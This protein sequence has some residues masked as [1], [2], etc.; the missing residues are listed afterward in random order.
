MFFIIAGALLLAYITGVFVSMISQGDPA[1]MHIVRKLSYV[2]NFIQK[3][4]VPPYLAKKVRRFFNFT[5][6][7][8]YM[9]EEAAVIAELPERLQMQVVLDLNEEFIKTIPMFIGKSTSFVF[10][11]VK[12]LKLDFAL[13]GFTQLKLL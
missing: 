10:A 11:V 1:R 8:E 7:R 4:K 12:R 9:D 6:R 5:V 2:D 3:R 13:V